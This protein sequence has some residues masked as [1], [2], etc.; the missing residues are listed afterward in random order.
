MTDTWNGPVFNL[1]SVELAYPEF[2]FETKSKVDSLAGVQR[3]NGLQK[4]CHQLW[5]TYVT[6]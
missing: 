1:H 2:Q 4:E 5:L 3:Y 6:Q